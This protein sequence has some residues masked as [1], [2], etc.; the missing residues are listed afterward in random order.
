MENAHAKTFQEVADFFGT[1][2]EKGLTPEQVKR[3]TEKYGPNGKSFIM[4]WF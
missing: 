1:D 3:L 2:L 4:I